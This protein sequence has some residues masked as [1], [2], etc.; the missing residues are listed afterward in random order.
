[1]KNEFD[2]CVSNYDKRFSFHV[3]NV[4]SI[5]N[6]INN[7]VMF[8]MGK[9]Q[10]KISN[11]EAVKQCLIFWQSEIAVPNG[12]TTNNA[13]VMAEEPRTEYCRFFKVNN[14][15]N[16]PKAEEF[17]FINGSFICNDAKV[18]ESCVIM[19]GAYIG[20]DV[21][22]GRNVYI[23]SGVK[24]V[25][26]VQIGDNVVIR[27]NAV[28]GADGLRTDRYHD[29]SA[30]TMPHFGG[31]VIGDDVDIGAN[32]VIAR[33]AI[34]NT[35]IGDGAKIDNSCFIS[36]GVHI[37]KHTFV[38]GETIM[39]GSSSCGERAFISG[40]STIRNGIHVGDDSTVG[41]GAVVTKSVPNNTVVMGN[42]AKSKQ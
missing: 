15:R 2:I 18:D 32:T 42:P 29:G 8:V 21:C 33:G 12:L 34:D 3:F 39:F 36:H 14:I 30:V 31:V 16:M 4:S 7:T 22:V 25:G 6:P 11:I 41:M 1:M 35:V 37:G 27:E 19:P 20:S 23:G 28:I 13:V 24:I 40:N 38:V 9:V 5:N 17:S 10:D 26:K